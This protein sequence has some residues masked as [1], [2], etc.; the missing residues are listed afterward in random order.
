MDHKLNLNQGSIVLLTNLLNSSGW[1]KTTVDIVL[2]GGVA[3]KLP[4]IVNEEKM[5]IAEFKHWSKVPVT[6]IVLNDKE[7]ECV[8]KCLKHFAEAGNIPGG[9]RS[10]ELLIAFGLD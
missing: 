2:S 8:R 6:E 1:C 10:A 3:M 7:R 9:T 5:T 4:D